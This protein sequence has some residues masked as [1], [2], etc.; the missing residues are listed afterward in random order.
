MTGND[1]REAGSLVGCHKQ[2]LLLHSATIT[3]LIAS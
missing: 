2:H 1:S 3:M